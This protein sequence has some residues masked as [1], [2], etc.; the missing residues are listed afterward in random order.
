MQ[1]GE[2]KE[3]SVRC[4]EKDHN[5]MTCTTTNTVSGD[6]IKIPQAGSFALYSFFYENFWMHRNEYFQ[7]L[8]ALL[9]K[10]RSHY[11]KRN[12]NTDLLYFE[13]LLVSIFMNSTK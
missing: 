10:F 12:K 3:N 11:E 1:F 5:P 9:K 6:A 7:S 8:I 13:V 4:D 2:Y